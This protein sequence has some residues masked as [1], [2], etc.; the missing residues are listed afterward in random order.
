MWTYE[1]AIEFTKNAAKKGSVLG[2]E[3]IQN[4]MAELNHVENEIRC[5]HIAGTNGK[6]STGAF[7]ESILIEAGMKVGRF[8]SPAVFDA[9]EVWKI[10]GQ[11]ISKK[12]YTTIMSQVKKACDIV[13]SKGF[14]EPTIFE[15]ETAAAFLYF[16]QN[17]VDIALI[18]VGMGGATDA[19]N[20]I[21]N[22]VA[23]V[24]TS[25]SMD[26]MAFLGDTL[27]EIAMVKA[28]IIKK[29]CPT[30]SAVQD[31][32]VANVLKK[33]TN[34]KN[35]QLVMVNPED[36]GYISLNIN[37][38]KLEFFYKNRKY[39]ITLLGEYQAKNATLAIETAEYLLKNINIIHMTPVEVEAVIFN[40]LKKT[41]WPGRFEIIKK[42]PVFIIDGAHNYDA[43]IQ[44]RHIIE[45]NFPKEQLNF[46]IGVL[47]DKEYGKII[48]VMI[49]FANRIIT[50]TTP[51]NPRA[52]DGEKLKEEI[53]KRNKKLE[54]YAASSLEEAAKLSIAWANEDGHK[55]IAFGSLSYL[56]EMKTYIKKL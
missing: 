46:I 56:G 35:S 52:L 8:S 13:V 42:E 4:L 25:I 48:D 9:F 36:I 43:A 31:A 6:G 33:V 27:S 16:Y 11:S 21:N 12:E 17:K 39:V 50:V 1:K 10:N 29:N 5:V 53:I 54:V 23:S 34:E 20:V 2:L 55:T 47:K 18:E 38:N 19:T 14:L 51:N 30:F 24:I 41:I 26:H 49:P 3:S 45:K 22:P 40:G 37:E 32:E 28:G 44:L 15:I 7:L